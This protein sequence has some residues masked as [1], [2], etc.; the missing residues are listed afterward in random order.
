MQQSN[1]ME[2]VRPI[3]LMDEIPW[4]E[5]EASGE[6]TN[7]CEDRFANEIET[8]FLRALLQHKYFPCDRYYENCYPLEKTIHIDGVLETIEDTLKL[9]DANHIASHD[10]YDQLQDEEDLEKLGRPMVWVDASLD[11]ERLTAARDALDGILPVRL[12][13]T[14]IYY[15]PWDQIPQLHGGVTNVY[16]D[17]MDRPEFMHAIMRR[18][19]ENQLS[20]MEQYEQLGLLDAE[21]SLVHCTPALCSQIPATDYSGGNYRLR[22]MWMRS[23]AQ[24]FSDISPAQHLEFDLAYQKPLFE[25]CGL[26]YYGCCEALHNKIRLL[27]DIPNLRKIGVSPWSDVRRTAEQVGSAYI[28]AIKPNPAMVAMK[29]RAEEVRAE[30]SSKLEIC[31]ANDCRCEFVLKD[32]STVS[33]DLRNL[34]LWHDTVNRTLDEYGF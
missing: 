16:L 8:F 1:D 21:Q 4:H 34:V 33:Y 13:G 12:R 31:L 18:L 28:L 22:D 7:R 27:K 15:S 29:T 14:W 2:A 26:V 10:Y 19:T 5:L 9:D 30:I 24:M 11:E 20:V 3:V 25:R 6:L 17:L 32:I 23:A